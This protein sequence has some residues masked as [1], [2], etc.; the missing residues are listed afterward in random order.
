MSR[1]REMPKPV[2]GLLIGEHPL[3]NAVWSFEEARWIAARDEQWRLWAADVAIQAAVG[4]AAGFKPAALVQF[5]EGLI[6]SF[7]REPTEQELRAAAH[8][9]TVHAD[10]IAAGQRREESGD[11]DQA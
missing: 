3:H 5:L 6:R 4:P 10:R 1:M 2:Q 9:L 11:A 7:G 8:A